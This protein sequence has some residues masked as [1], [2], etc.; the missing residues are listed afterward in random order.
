MIVSIPLT[1]QYNYALMKWLSVLIVLLMCTGY[2]ALAFEMKTINP[3]YY[4]HVIEAVLFSLIVMG[5][6]IKKSPLLNK[7]NPF[8]I[9]N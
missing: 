2:I 9:F 7:R 4:T 6:F 1:L 5:W 3:K 8:Q